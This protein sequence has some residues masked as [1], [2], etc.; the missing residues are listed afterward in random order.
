M[1]Y[2]KSGEQ[3]VHRIFVLVWNM[4]K[5]KVANIIKN[6]DGYAEAVFTDGF[7]MFLPLDKIDT[8]KTGMYVM[9]HVNKRGTTVAYSWGDNMRFVDLQPIHY[10][11][12]VK[13][14][15]DFKLL[16]RVR[17]NASLVQAMH[18]RNRNPIFPDTNAFAHNLVLFGIKGWFKSR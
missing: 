17:F 2:N 8:L 3:V 13:F 9:E 16:D 5:H 11:E 18:Y 4:K 12:A 15:Q 1:S 14:I 7:T 10:D 6:R